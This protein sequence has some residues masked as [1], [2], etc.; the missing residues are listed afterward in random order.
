MTDPDRTAQLEHAC[1]TLV[2]ALK[3]SNAFALGFAERQ[4]GAN[5][6]LL[7]FN[8]QAQ[9]ALNEAARVLPNVEEE[10]RTRGGRLAYSG[11]ASPRAPVQ[12]GK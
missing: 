5:A 10:G 9:A 2:K 6:A 8:T 12:A 7:M 4:I 1:R 3:L 11:D